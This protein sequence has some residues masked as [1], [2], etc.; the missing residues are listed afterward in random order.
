MFLGLDV[1]AGGGLDGV[2]VRVDQ[3]DRGLQALG[4]VVDQPAEQAGDAGDQREAVSGA[5]ALQVVGA[6][7]RLLPSQTARRM[8]S[9]SSTS[10]AM[11][12]PRCFRASASAP[13][14]AKSS[15]IV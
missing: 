4:L 13:V 7:V 6:Q 12:A 2:D 11:A 1:V 9:M 5:Q 14:P 3:R 10:D 15:A 8:S